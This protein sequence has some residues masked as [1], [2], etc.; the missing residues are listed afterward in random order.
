MS[1]RRC[2]DVVVATIGLAVGGP[3]VLA[4]ATFAAWRGRRPA[5]ARVVCAGHLGRPIA[6]TVI[7]HAERVPGLFDWRDRVLL[8]LPVLSGAMTLV[9]PLPRPLAALA[10]YSPLE[11]RL[12]DV[13]PGIVDLASLVFP[14]A[15]RILAAS[16]DPALDHD[17]LLRP[18]LNRFDLLYVSDR[19]PALDLALV[20]TT[21]AAA[22]SRSAAERRIETLLADLEAPAELRRIAR[23]L[24]P[25][26]PTPPPGA[27]RPVSASERRPREDATRSVAV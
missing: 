20:A 23:R 12:L 3:I 5:L 18:W 13:K 22:V 10:S 25:L 2:I 21:F 15:R 4:A 7:A 8:L 24:D 14:D 17:R 19:R 1:A 16:V 11:R 9:G 6:P 27:N 26:T